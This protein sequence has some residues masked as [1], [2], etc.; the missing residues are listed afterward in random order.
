MQKITNQ[1]RS[2]I[3][4]ALVLIFVLALFV[5]PIG[6]LMPKSSDMLML[7]VF[8]IVFLVYLGIVWKEYA[9]DEREHAH[10]QTAGRISFFAGTSVVAT[11]IVVQA[12]GHNID[13]W[14]VYS[15]GIMLLTK[16]AVR[17]YSQLTQ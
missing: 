13:P 10:Q 15:L 7:A 3:V 5:S 2:E 11:G 9:R 8:V 16:I 17:I 6:L 14:L 12:F 1:Y 4:I